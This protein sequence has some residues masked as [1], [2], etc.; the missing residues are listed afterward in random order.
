L[1]CADFGSELATALLSSL[2]AL[3]QLIDLALIPPPI[4]EGRVYLNVKSTPIGQVKRIVG[5]PDA[6]LLA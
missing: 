6:A 4:E 1:A 3:R 5:E 2:D